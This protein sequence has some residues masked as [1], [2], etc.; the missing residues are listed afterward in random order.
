MISL[1]KLILFF[2]ILPTDKPRIS[3]SFGGH[4]QPD[5]IKEGVDIYLDCDVKANPT[6]TTI[7]WAHDVSDANLKKT[8][9]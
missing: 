4:L 7:Q 9:F 8:D 3:L 5:K 1:S 2:I 6:V